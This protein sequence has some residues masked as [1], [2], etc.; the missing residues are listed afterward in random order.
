MSDECPTM[1]LPESIKVANWIEVRMIEDKLR[2]ECLVQMHGDFSRECSI[3]KAFHVQVP[4]L[5]LADESRR[6]LS[7]WTTPLVAAMLNV[8]HERAQEIPPGNAEGHEYNLNEL[9]KYAGYLN[10]MGPEQRNEVEAAWRLGAYIVDAIEAAR[11][12]R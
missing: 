7:T 4:E 10:A 3:I 5:D 12:K 8:Y 11:G 1:S 2:N 9:K 6:I